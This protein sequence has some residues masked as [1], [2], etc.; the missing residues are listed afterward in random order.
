MVVVALM[1]ATGC[2]ARPRTLASRFVIAGTPIVDVGGVVAPVVVRGAASTDARS[3][4]RPLRVIAARYSGSAALESTS[5]VLQ[6]AL[7][8]LALAP[9][10]R[11]YL[12]V[13][14]A[15]RRLGV[16]DTAVDFLLAGLRQDAADAALHDALARAWRDWGFPDRGLAAAHRAVYHAPGSAEARNTLGTV[17]WALGDRAGA[18]RA[19]A[20]AAA[21][22]P[23]AGYAW[24]NLCTAQLAAGRTRDAVA[25]CRRAAQA[26]GTVREAVP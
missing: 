6:R 19:F 23:R 1:A 25:S 4:V 22:D 7:L 8:A 24:R 5:P 26:R 16:V 21:L 11:R 15:Y 2:A 18:G 14:A 17:L 3:D 13:A 20:E 10:G 9:S 12:E